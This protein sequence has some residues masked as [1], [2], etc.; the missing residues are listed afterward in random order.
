M[1]KSNE[2]SNV[3]RHTEQRPDRMVLNV[4]AIEA[5][6]RNLADGAVTPHYG[7]WSEDIVLLLNDAL[8]T[9]LVCVLRYK[10]HHSV[11]GAGVRGGAMTF[12]FMRISWPK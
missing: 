11:L 7:P 4:D 8:A 6:R 1:T 12:G 10:R 3:K 5:A 9:E 2:P